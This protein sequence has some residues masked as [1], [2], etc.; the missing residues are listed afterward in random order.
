MH[1]AYRDAAWNVSKPSSPI[2]RCL[3]VGTSR[4]AILLHGWKL[5]GI[6]P[7]AVTHTGSQ[8]RAA[9]RRI[10]LGFVDRRWS[11]REAEQDGSTLAMRSKMNPL[12]LSLVPAG[13]R[14][15]CNHRITVS[16]S[17]QLVFFDDSDESES[18]GWLPESSLLL[19]LP[20][21]PSGVSGR[22]LA[23]D[24]IVWHL[25]HFFVVTCLGPPPP[26][27]LLVFCSVSGMIGCCV[28]DVF[29]RA[30]SVREVI[31]NALT[32]LGCDIERESGPSSLLRQCSSCVTGTT[33]ASPVQKLSSSLHRGRR[34]NASC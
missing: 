12:R 6:R 27:L 20:H 22:I 5:S 28:I 13:D 23:K 24:K 2:S 7:T 17:P 30:F 26:L 8:T 33:T 29:R 11:D 21:L 34:C 25:V 9:D 19:Q 3:K 31:F 32:M 1:G 14:K 4:T 18:R 16:A 10:L 15:N